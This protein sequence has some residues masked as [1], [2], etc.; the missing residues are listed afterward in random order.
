MMALVFVVVLIVVM[1]MMVALA[2]RIVALVIVVVMML[3]FQRFERRF[4]RIAL[5]DRGKQIGA[6][7]RVPRRGDDR[8][9]GIQ[10]AHHVE[11]LLKAFFADVLRTRKHHAVRGFDLVHIEF[12]EVLAIDAR[13]LGV[14][15]RDAAVDHDLVVENAADRRLDVGKLADAGRFDQDAVGMKLVQHLLERL[16]EVADERAA[17]AAGVHLGDLDARLLQERAVDA[18]LAEFVLDQHE[19]FTRKAFGDHL[20]DQRRLACA[21]KSTENID[22]CHICPSFRAG[23]Q[24]RLFFD[25]ILSHFLNFASFILWTFCEHPAGIRTAAQ[26]SRSGRRAH[27]A[28][29][30]C[31]LWNRTAFSDRCPSGRPFRMRRS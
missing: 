26:A 21:Q 17:D 15:D 5:F 20:L 6:G 24:P 19:L 23:K 25:A 2:F 3:G 10:L 18:D 31:T 11:H 13:L 8:R 16:G 9:F 22:F 29:S 28:R 7:E 4:Q 12:A 30:G 1:V 27:S 14:D